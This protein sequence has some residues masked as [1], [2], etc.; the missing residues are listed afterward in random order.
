VYPDPELGCRWTSGLVAYTVREQPEIE[1][2]LTPS[3]VGQTKRTRPAREKSA[4]VPV[5][6]RRAYEKPA[7]CACP[8][9]ARNN[10]RCAVRAGSKPRG[11]ARSGWPSW[12]H[13]QAGPQRK[14]ACEFEGPRAP[15]FPA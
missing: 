1:G 15:E 9:R 4:D 12:G 13:L 2:Q 14:G 6:N 3:S 8:C 10:S 11:C 7:N 5:W